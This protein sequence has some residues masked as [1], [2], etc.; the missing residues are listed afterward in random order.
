MQLVLVLNLSKV[1]LELTG[2][3]R[4]FVKNPLSFGITQRI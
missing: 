4:S 1:D 2:S 3:R